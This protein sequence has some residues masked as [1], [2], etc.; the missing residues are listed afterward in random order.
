MENLKCPVCGS[1][2][3]LSALNRYAR[4]SSPKCWIHRETFWV[5]LTDWN[6]PGLRIAEREAEKRGVQKCIEAIKEEAP[7]WNPGGIIVSQMIIRK[8]ERLLK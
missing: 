7:N 5:A 1:E 6:N 4:C 8:L 3:K 2:P